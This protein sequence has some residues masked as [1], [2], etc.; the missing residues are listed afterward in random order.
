MASGDDLTP[1]QISDIIA[2][3]NKKARTINRMETRLSA[4]RQRVLDA[5]NRPP[6][7]ETDED[8]IFPYGG[9]LIRRA[10]R[11]N[12][13]E[14]SRFRDRDAFRG[15]DWIYNTAWSLLS[16]GDTSRFG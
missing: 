4:K 6:P 16:W 8:F 10:E 5:A 13:L 14:Q 15:G 1:Q 11:R 3:D 12:D 9:D 7:V 2:R